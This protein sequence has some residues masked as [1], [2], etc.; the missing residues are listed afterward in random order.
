MSKP[1]ARGESRRILSFSTSL[2][3]MLP[4]GLLTSLGAPEISLQADG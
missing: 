1:S 3:K 2:K 4:T